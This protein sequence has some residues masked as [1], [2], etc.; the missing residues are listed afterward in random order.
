MATTNSEV[1]VEP[2]TSASDFPRFFDITALTFGHQIGDGIWSAFNPAWDTP[3]GREAGI[4]RLVS[5]WSSTTRDRNGSPN[6][7]FLKAVVPRNGRES[8]GGQGEDIAGVA[9]WVQASNVAGYGD[10]PVTDVSH[11]MDLNTLYPGDLNEQRYLRQVDASLHGRRV[12]MVNE[13]AGSDSPAVFVLDLCVVDPAFQRRGI[14]KKLVEWGL[15]EAKRRGGLEAVTEASAMGRHV[16][17]Q[18]GFVQ[19]GG[20]MECRVDEQFQGRPWPS[21]VFMRTGR[22]Q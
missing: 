3:S 17:R 15:K 21:N 18:L 14:A 2:I 12:E 13:I 20:E 6:T 19:E 9:I 1:R 10:K 11:A 8:E 7:I 22:P 5:R 16:Y 4:S